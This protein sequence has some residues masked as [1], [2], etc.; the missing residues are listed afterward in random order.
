MI[1]L[2][3]L[4]FNKPIK[5]HPSK[6]PL[7]ENEP[8]FLVIEE[9]SEIFGI[10]LIELVSLSFDLNNVTKTSPFVPTAPLWS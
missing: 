5:S 6:F 4:P 10:Y 8:N 2:T 3:V 9:L 7:A 1:S